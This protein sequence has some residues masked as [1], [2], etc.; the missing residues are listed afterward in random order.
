MLKVILRLFFPNCLLIL[1]YKV[2]ETDSFLLWYTL[3][4]VGNPHEK[5]RVFALYYLKEFAFYNDWMLFLSSQSSWCLNLAL[6]A[7]IYFDEL[8]TY[9]RFYVRDMK[10]RVLEFDFILSFPPIFQFSMPSIS[11][12]KFAKHYGCWTTHCSHTNI[13]EL[14]NVLFEMEFTLNNLTMVVL[15]SRRFICIV[16]KF[17]I[18]KLLVVI[19]TT[20]LLH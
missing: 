7:K 8:N 5:Y 2:H 20:Y 1:E 14:K 17:K 12:L 15:L 3:G 11:T 10:S 6:L 9:F 18:S 19:W 13:F 16:S 4:G